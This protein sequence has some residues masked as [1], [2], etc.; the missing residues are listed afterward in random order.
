MTDTVQRRWISEIHQRTASPALAL[1]VVL[2]LG[3]GAAQSAQAQT[4]TV[5]YSFTG[6]SD[7][8]D[9]YAGLLRDAAGNLYGTTEF[10]GSSNDGVVF[11]IS[12]TGKE[13]VLHSFTGGATTA[14]SPCTQVFTWTRR[15]TF[16][17]SRRKAELPVK[18]SFTN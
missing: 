10:G 8:G 5:L 11:K 1:A 13:T 6:S 16:T 15:A 18:E 14:E 12:K 2:V 9:P 4:L 7:G 3:L 17:T